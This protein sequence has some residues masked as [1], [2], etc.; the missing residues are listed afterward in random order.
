[1]T[2]PPLCRCEALPLCHCEARQCRSNLAFMSLRGA[3]QRSKLKG[4]H[5]RLPRPDKSGLAM[6]A[7][8]SVIARLSSLCRCEALSPFLSLREAKRRSNL[9]SFTV[10]E[11]QTAK[12][13]RGLVT[14]PPLSVWW[15]FSDDYA[16]HYGLAALIN[17]T[18][19]FVVVGQQ[20]VKSIYLSF[21]T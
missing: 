13:E 12:P 2:P 7:I 16:I 14:Q 5:V 11:L 9:L 1:M 6:T 15:G 21:I 10:F 4:N 17:R 20:H 18:T 3:Q 19:S 8:V